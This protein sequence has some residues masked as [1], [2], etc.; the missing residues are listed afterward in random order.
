L[1]KKNN[2]NIDIS[3]RLKIQRLIKIE[4]VFHQKSEFP[5][6]QNLIQ[7]K[8][9]IGLKFSRGLTLAPNHLNEQKNSKLCI[10]FFKRFFRICY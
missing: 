1:I 10:Y 7:K 9:E 2:S 5:I 6:Y 4:E 8:N 3:E